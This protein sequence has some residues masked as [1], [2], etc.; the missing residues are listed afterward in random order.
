MNKIHNEIEK[1]NALNPVNPELSYNLQS[2]A[3]GGI[4]CI[5]AFVASSNFLMDEAISFMVSKNVRR[6]D[7]SSGIL[8]STRRRAIA[9]ENDE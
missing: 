2:C 9:L 3:P 1:N 4:I 6:S 8:A 5:I 7:I